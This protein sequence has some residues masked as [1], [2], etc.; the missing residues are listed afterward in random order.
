MVSPP[1]LGPLFAPAA[2]APA[3]GEGSLQAPRIRVPIDGGFLKAAHDS[4]RH[5]GRNV[6]PLLCKRRGPIFNLC[7]AHEEII[8]TLEGWPAREREVA[9]RSQAVEVPAGIKR[10]VSQ[11]LLR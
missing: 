8:R 10:T 11:S 2:G 6:A 1:F 3:L 5:I 7:P 9:H 4:L